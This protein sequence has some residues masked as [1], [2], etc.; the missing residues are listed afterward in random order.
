[1]CDNDCYYVL[2][3]LLQLFIFQF[4][5]FPLLG[6]S[7]VR[8]LLFTNTLRGG[9]FMSKQGGKQAQSPS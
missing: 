3:L 7:L 1:M 6:K 2:D 9:N 5:A 8:G 4:L